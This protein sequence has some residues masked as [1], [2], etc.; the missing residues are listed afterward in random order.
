MGSTVQCAFLI[1]KIVFEQRYEPKQA[2]QENSLGKNNPRRVD[3]GSGKVQH[4]CGLL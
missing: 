2:A 3:P 4:V 1:Q